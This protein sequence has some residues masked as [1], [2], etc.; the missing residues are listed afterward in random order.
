VDGNG[1]SRFFTSN[2]NGTYSNAEDF[3]SLVQQGSSYVDMAKD[4]TVYNFSSTGQLTSVVDRS[5]LTTSYTYTS[6]LL[7][8]VTAPDGGSTVLRYD[9][10]NFLHEVTEPGSRNFLPA[11]IGLTKFTIIAGSGA[12]FLLA[13][14]IGIRRIMTRRWAEL[15]PALVRHAMYSWLYLSYY[16]TLSKGDRWCLLVLFSASLLGGIILEVDVSQVVLVDGL[17]FV[18]FVIWRWPP[19][20]DLCVK[21]WNHSN[22]AMR[23]WIC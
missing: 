17:C 2:G 6:G 18:L 14:L 23:K 9:T 12:F 5:G 7:T 22:A 16:L 19:S 4:Q 8:G 20:R 13:V 15:R 10:H 1:D 11:P 21:W 3:G